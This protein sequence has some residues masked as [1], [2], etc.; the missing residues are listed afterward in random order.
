MEYLVHFRR[1]TGD[2]AS[3]VSP[4][5]FKVL[6]ILLPALRCRKQMHLTLQPCTS[7]THL[8]AF[9]WIDHTLDPVKKPTETISQSNE[10]INCPLR[11][12]KLC[13]QLSQITVKL[14]TQTLLSSLQKCHRFT[15]YS[16]IFT[17]NQK[18]ERHTS[19]FMHFH[20]LVLESFSFCSSI[21]LNF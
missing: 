3:P 8:K 15:I 1:G 17:E 16:C 20:E 10:N 2:M 4:I 13:L 19:K 21:E 12:N 14:Q 7:L 18:N 5:I 9:S 11:S 6:S